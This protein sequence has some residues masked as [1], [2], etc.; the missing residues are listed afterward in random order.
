MESMKLLTKTGLHTFVGNW[1]IESFELFA[2]NAIQ[3]RKK[4]KYMNFV[5]LAISEKEKSL[6]QSK[7]ERF[8]RERSDSKAQ[9]ALPSKEVGYCVTG[10]DFVDYGRVLAGEPECM[11]YF[12][13]SHKP[14]KFKEVRLR[15]SFPSLNQEDI[16]NYYTKIIDLIDN[17]EKLG[18]KCKVFI[19]I[20]YGQIVYLGQND[21]D[22]IVGTILLKEENEVFDLQQFCTVLMSNYLPSLIRGLSKAIIGDDKSNF[23]TDSGGNFKEILYNP[24]EPDCIKF[25]SVRILNDYIEFPYYKE[26]FGKHIS[27]Y[28]GLDLL[29]M[30]Q[31]PV[32]DFE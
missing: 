25:P 15:I 14:N 24:L 5:R 26:S 2:T 23:V 16:F 13:E 21:S 32:S 3:T 27:N 7:V 9:I 1:N 8:N 28:T 11:G 12:A 4:G 29:K 10:G 18:T 6:E 19:D 20:S 30:L 22:R 17:W 31:A